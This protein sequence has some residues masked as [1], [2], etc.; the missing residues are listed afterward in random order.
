M[1]RNRAVAAQRGG[2]VCRLGRRRQL[3]LQLLLLLL[4]PLLLYELRRRSCSCNRPRRGGLRRL[5]ARRVRVVVRALAGGGVVPRARGDAAAAASARDRRARSVFTCGVRARARARAVR[6]RLPV[7]LASHGVGVFR[8]C[9]RGRL[10][11]LGWLGWFLLGS[12]GGS[13]GGRGGGRGGGSGDGRGGWSAGGN[14]GWSAGGRSGGGIGF[15][16]RVLLRLDAQVSSDLVDL[17]LLV[18]EAVADAEL[19]ADVVDLCCG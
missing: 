7:E 13:R 19:L 4:L 8:P 16:E 2:D 5:L 14:G 6:V 9:G 3:Q 15:F 11:R 1:E 17:V 10:G 18:D 12:R